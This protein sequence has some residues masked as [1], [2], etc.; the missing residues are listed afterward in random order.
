MYSHIYIV[1]IK[2]FR[3]TLIVS[4]LAFACACSVPRPHT[5]SPRETEPT[6]P[7]FSAWP[8]HEQAASELNAR[9]MTGDPRAQDFLRGATGTPMPGGQATC[10][11][12]L[13]AAYRRLR[14]MSSSSTASPSSCDPHESHALEWLMTSVTPQTKEARREGLGLLALALE[15]TLCPVD[16]TERQRVLGVLTLRPE[17]DI[18]HEECEPIDW[19][20]GW[21]GARSIAGVTEWLER[22]RPDQRPGARAMS[23]VFR[24][25]LT[26]NLGDDEPR[27]VVL[28]WLPALAPDEAIEALESSELS[29]TI[30]SV[31]QMLLASRRP[32]NRVW[33]LKLMID[34]ARVHRV[35]SDSIELAS[36]LL[37]SSSVGMGGSSC[38]PRPGGHRLDWP[39]VAAVNER[40]TRQSQ[41]LALRVKDSISDEIGVSLT[42]EAAHEIGACSNVV[43][44]D[45]VPMQELPRRVPGPPADELEATR[46][47][48][49]DG[50]ACEP[51]EFGWSPCEGG[52]GARVAGSTSWDQKTDLRVSVRHAMGRGP[53]CD[54]VSFDA[55]LLEP[56]ATPLLDCSG[57]LALERAGA[58]TV[59]HVEDS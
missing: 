53:D 24:T 56:D 38:R 15:H 49:R 28:R 3:N 41:R 12:A 57:T 10:G 23:A 33:G 1:R 36:L 43:E 39:P 52:W 21:H 35:A 34:A 4:L 8:G 2:H 37:W 47:G 54:V 50:G 19:V 13:G 55:G 9:A 40:V 20:Q 22:V 42:A 32:R 26:T 25:M 18:A 45:P 6:L 44:R 27:V 30:M 59:V 14:G 5:P 58:W 16:V 11:H 46:A 7:V 31:A 29:R 51:L 17:H 48:A